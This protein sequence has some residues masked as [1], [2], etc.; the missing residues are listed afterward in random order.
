MAKTQLPYLLQEALATGKWQLQDLGKN[1]ETYTRGSAKIEIG[2]VPLR[3]TEPPSYVFRLA[4][5]EA[6]VQKIEKLNELCA[7]LAKQNV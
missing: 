2:I 4:T 3:G 5:P 1:N 6:S 7:R